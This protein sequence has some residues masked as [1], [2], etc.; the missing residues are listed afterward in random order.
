MIPMD[1][2]TPRHA[3]LDYAA[4]GVVIALLTNLLLSW[5]RLDRWFQR[6]AS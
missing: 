5:E 6:E 2:H 4:P 3:F 1:E